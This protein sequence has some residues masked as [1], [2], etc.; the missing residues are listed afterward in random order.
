[1]TNWEMIDFVN[2]TQTLGQKKLPIKLM[3]ALLQNIEKLKPYIN[4]YN[5]AIAKA[6]TEEERKELL[7]D[8][9]DIELKKVPLNYD[10]DKYDLL[11]VAEYNALM[12]MGDED[13]A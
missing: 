11:T 8:T 5:E 6:G 9:I 1:M 12:L 10:E 4:A 3:S 2:G 13:N 7:N